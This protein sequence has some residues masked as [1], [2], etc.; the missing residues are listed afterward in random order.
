VAALFDRNRKDLELEATYVH[1]WQRDPFARGAYSYVAVGGIRA[2]ELLAA[3]LGGTLYFA[4]E[5]TDT[6]GDAATVTGAL[7]SGARAAVE[8]S[9]QLERRH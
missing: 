8:V 6:T 3:P 4:G 5:A 7:R 2:R 9:R 1:N